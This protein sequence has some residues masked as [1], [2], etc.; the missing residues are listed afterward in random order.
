MFIFV[1]MSN[2]DTEVQGKISKASRH[3]AAKYI[4]KEEVGMKSREELKAR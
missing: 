2:S 4:W 1:L 3:T